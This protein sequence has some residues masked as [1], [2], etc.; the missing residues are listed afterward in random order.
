MSGN[1]LSDISECPQKKT[2]NSLDFLVTNNITSKR[3]RLAQGCL[4]DVRNVWRIYF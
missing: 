1:N 4:L 2:Q 3:L